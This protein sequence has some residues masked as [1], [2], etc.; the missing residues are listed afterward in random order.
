MALP[1]GVGV[2][3]PHQAEVPS[4]PAVYEYALTTLDG[5]PNW[6]HN[7]KWPAVPVWSG[8]QFMLPSSEDENDLDDAIAFANA[9]P[10]Q[11]WLM[12]HRPEINGPD[13]QTSAARM[14]TWVAGKPANTKWALGGVVYTFP[15]PEFPYGI[16]TAQD[17]LDEYLAADGPVPDAWHINVIGGSTTVAATFHWFLNAHR[18]WMIA[19]DVQKP[20]IVSGVFWTQEDLQYQ[21][22]L[23]DQCI[24]EVGAGGYARAIAWISAGGYDFPW[25]HLI[26]ADGHVTAMGDYY[27]ESLR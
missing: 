19:N 15:T 26:D 17:W 3:I 27:V 25:T 22:A 4:G 2:V 21:K 16:N 1:T 14:Q 9:H 20:L 24:V 10:S 13:A 6:W 8:R 12:E 18:S 11:G 7:W 5:T 23:L